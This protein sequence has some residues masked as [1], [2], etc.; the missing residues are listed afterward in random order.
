VLYETIRTSEQQVN[1]IRLNSSS[2]GLPIAIGWGRNRVSGNLIW[3]GDFRAV[4]NVTTTG[5]KGGPEVEQ[6]TYTY[7]ASMMFALG[8]GQIEN[9]P[10]VY[11]EKAKYTPAQLGFSVFTG[12]NPSPWAY[13]AT[14]HPSETLHYKGVAYLAAGPYRLS[15]G[16]SIAPHS[17]E[18]DWGGAVGG[19]G[20]VVDANPAVVLHDFLTNPVYGAGID[21]SALEDSAPYTPFYFYCEAAGLYVSPLVSQQQEARA[22]VQQWLEAMGA[23]AVWSQGRFRVVP[24]ADDAIGSW[25]PDVSV[26]W[27]IT[28]DYLLEPTRVVRKT[29]ADAFNVVRVEF[30]NRATDYN[31]DVAEAQDDTSIAAI[32]LR[33]AP[34]MT[35]HFI[36]DPTVARAVAQLRL[37]RHQYVRAHYIVKVPWLL[38]GLE[39][40]DVV[41][42]TDPALSLQSILVRVVEVEIDD[43]N[44]VTLTCEDF[45]A[46]SGTAVAY[47]NSGSSG[48]IPDSS[49]PPGNANAPVL[50]EPPLAFS[51]EPSVFVA[52][53]GGVDWGGCE[54]WAS[55]DDVNY[56]RVAT[57]RGK[58]RHGVLAASFAVGASVDAVNDLEV[59]LS[60]SGGALAS[61]SNDDWAAL[62]NPAWVD[63]EIVASQFAELE[64][65]SQYTL[66]NHRRGLFGTA[67]A[68]HPVNAP[69]VR[70]DESVARVPYSTAD[71]GKTIHLKLVSFNTVG[72]ARQ[73]ISSVAAVSYVVQG[74]PPPVIAGL[75]LLQ[76]FTGS[77]VKVKW[78]VSVG[79]TSY[80]V[81][82]EVG[83]VT[84]RTVS[85]IGTNQFEYTFEDARADGG[86]W[87]SLTVKV[88]ADGPTGSSAYTSLSVT[89]AQAA[90]PSGITVTATPSGVIVKTD[91]AADTDF[92]GMVV[93]ASTTNNFTPA[94]GNKVY[95]GK[96]VATPPLVL[97]PGTTHYL[98]VAHYDQ[99]GQDSL[100]YSAQL[101]VTPQRSVLV[102]SSLP[103]SANVDDCVLLTTN[104]T[105]YRWNGSAWV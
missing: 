78:D 49:V 47:A 28:P 92:A 10:I 15:D 72:V 63:G 80:T 19:V 60:V 79:A 18:V 59:D 11:K 12:Q 51:G 102:V 32:G 42:I 13:L 21:P 52:T 62:S 5:G 66:T 91:P 39:P 25:S 20:N 35:C 84:E 26:R 31:K 24:Y 38:M 41:A 94:A 73:D 58:A 37:Q 8:Y 48:Y 50:F 4:A 57:I 7:Y 71:I 22:Y 46:E 27:H 76:P 64:A 74:A 88:R 81:Q 23:A 69:F 61:V 29:V 45:P 103:A 14:N 89:N 16:A 33:P 97:S 56:R 9:V 75:T 98:R 3:Y 85:N 67:I 44:V 53:S 93:H 100:N 70:L 104:M 86:P 77:S 36:C 90:A 6:T 82:I 17:F 2:Q 30:L 40:M 1:S 65:L 101:S 83:G 87:R 54:V 55:Y 43:D 105:L 68:A 95:D 34:T 99:F 96:D